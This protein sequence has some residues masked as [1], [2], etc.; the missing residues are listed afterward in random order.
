MEK[1]MHDL[2]I[3]KIHAEISNLMAQT[4]KLNR[5][6]MLYPMVVTATFTLA[7]VAVV[8]LFV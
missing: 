5:E 2:E 1:T 8:K 4:T 7:M 6:S 3:E